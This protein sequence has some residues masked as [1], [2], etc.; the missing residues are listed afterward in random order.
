[1]SKLIVIEG[2]CDGVGK[3]TQ[4]NMLKEHLEKDNMKVYCHHFPTY[5]SDAGKLIS[6]YLN[7]K[8]GS[9]QNISPYFI[10]SLYAI[11]RKIVSDNISKISNDIIL[12]DR[13]TT[14]SL[15]YQTALIDDLEEKKKFIDYI[16][17]YEY[18]KLLIR[19]PDKVIFLTLPFELITENRNKRKNNSCLSKDIH[20]ENEEYLKKVYDNATF[21]S[22][23]LSWNVVDCYKNNQMK[24]KEEIHNE[25]YKLI[26]SK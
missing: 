18:N 16:I 24:S 21:I 19:Q 2:A 11:D 25:V 1:M 3:T 14:S 17:D 23:Y 4:V 5:D 26:K 9:I 8:Y 10:N 15:I 7:G 12:L 6:N 13:Y 22:N 20:E